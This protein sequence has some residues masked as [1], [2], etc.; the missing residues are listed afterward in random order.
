MPSEAGSVVNPEWH[1]R[2]IWYSRVGCGSGRAA[3][4][5]VGRRGADRAVHD[6]DAGGRRS[7]GPTRSSRRLPAPT[8]R[9]SRCGS[10]GSPRT[11][12]AGWRRR[13]TR[14]PERGCERWAPWRWSRRDGSTRCAPFGVPA[15]LSGTAGSV[16]CASVLRLEPEL[17]SSWQVKHIAAWGE[18]RTARCGALRRMGPVADRARVRDEGNVRHM[19]R[20]ERTGVKRVLLR[21]AP[22]GSPRRAGSGASRPTRARPRPCRT[23]SPAGHPPR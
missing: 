2:Q 21:P 13:R 9:P 5:G 8:R 7:G 12:C 15:L 14:C 16:N 11:R 18:A 20:G 22:S 17:T 23:G 4:E 19:R 10:C 1:L 6:G 3:E